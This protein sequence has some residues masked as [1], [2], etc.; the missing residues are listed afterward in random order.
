[1]FRTP[2]FLA[3]ALSLAG[4]AAPLAAPPARPSGPSGLT[5]HAA[6]EAG[7]RLLAA[8]ERLPSTGAPK[9]PGAGSPGLEPPP[10]PLPAHILKM[11]QVSSL[12][13]AE[14]DTQETFAAR[15]AVTDRALAHI[16]AIKLTGFGKRNVPVLL[17][18]LA[19]RG[20]GYMGL[21]PT[22]ETRYLVQV[23]VLEFLRAASAEASLSAGSPLFKLGATMV[24]ATTTHDQGFRVG[25][26]V[27][28]VLEA[29]YA[30][31]EL[32]KACRAL[33]EQS[34]RAPS[35]EAACGVIRDGLLELGRRAGH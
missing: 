26:S 17:G 8:F 14:A 24:D 19:A 16:D 21:P 25:I 11:R 7:T 35:R 32:R 1:M 23:P 10:Q 33:A 29:H 28:S 5:P 12:A 31:R 15:F 22:P 13:L 4:C 27:L 3:I 18:R 20:H 34:V 6:D 2:T 30:Q 9:A